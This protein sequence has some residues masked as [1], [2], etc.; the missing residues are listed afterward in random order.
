MNFRTEIR[1]TG[2]KLNKFSGSGVFTI[3]CNKI[4]GSR[5]ANR[6]K[7]TLLAHKVAEK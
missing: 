3:G 1:S 4:Y 5:K 7:C 6:K 2:R